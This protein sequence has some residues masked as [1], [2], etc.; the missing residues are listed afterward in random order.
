MSFRNLFAAAAL[1]SAWVAVPYN[2]S[3]APIVDFKITESGQP[4]ITFSLPESPTPGASVSG[5]AFSIFNVPT[6]KGTGTILF[7][8]SGGLSSPFA[9]NLTSAQLYT[10]PPA[11]Q[12]ASPTFVPGVYPATDNLNGGA[13]ASIDITLETAAGAPGP[14]VGA[15]LPG[16]IAACGGLL[17]L[18]RR[19]RQRMA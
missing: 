9:F 5:F 4:D 15:G 12:E 2:A 6:S 13:A 1:A 14:V 11:D 3:A 18:G 7:F 17:A 19:R 10:G 8:E 16:L